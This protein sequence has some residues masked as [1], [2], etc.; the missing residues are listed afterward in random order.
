MLCI[1]KFPVAKKFI[2]KREGE[3]SRFPLNFFCFKVSKNA[4]RE[5]FSVSL[6]SGIEKKWMRGWGGGER[7]CQDFPS[8]ISCLPVPKNFVG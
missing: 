1:R 5:P 8:K 7:E 4:E 6:I 3:V 2:D